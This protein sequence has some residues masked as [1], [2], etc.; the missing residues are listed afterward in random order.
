MDDNRRAVEEAAELRASCLVLVCGPAAGCSLEAARAYVA[1]AVARLSEDAAAHGVVLAVEPLHPMYCADRSV[2]VTLDQA[3][4]VATSAG[5]P[6]RVGVVVDA[7]HVWWDPNLYRQVA[8]SAGRICGFHVSDWLVPTP[9]MLNGRGLM[10]DGVIELRRLREAV[11][12]AGYDGPIE[13]EIFNQG[14]WALPAEEALNLVA[15]RYLT[16]VF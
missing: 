14:L 9:D 3:L 5:L 8:A 16:H 15:A 13:V 12:D 2:I 4:A 10:G 6:E 11:D 1:E 7:Y